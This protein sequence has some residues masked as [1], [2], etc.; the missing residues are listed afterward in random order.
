[1]KNG[2]GLLVVATVLFTAAFACN[3]S[4]ANMAS[5][6]LFKDKDGKTE[7]TS[8]KGGETIYGRA[9]IANNGGKVKVKMQVNV[10]DAA[11]MTKGDIVKGSEVTVD[12]DGDGTA[13]YSLPIPSA[14]KGGKYIV[15]ADMI[16][17]AGEKK[18]SKSVNIT[19]TSDS[20]SNTSDTHG[21]RDK[22]DN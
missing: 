5:F 1:M 11:G 16:N 14:V 20:S 15:T 6:K 18:D 2:I 10:D 8:Y 19:V 7:T 4:T 13:T 21:D 22:D 3:M 17:D 12:M 9:V